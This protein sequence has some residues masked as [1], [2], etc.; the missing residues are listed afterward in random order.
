MHSYADGQLNGFT[1]G[2]ITFSNDGRI[3]IWEWK[4]SKTGF[5]VDKNADGGALQWNPFKNLDKW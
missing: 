1:R 4:E 3:H 5:K 2:L